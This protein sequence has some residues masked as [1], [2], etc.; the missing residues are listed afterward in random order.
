MNEDLGEDIKLYEKV[1]EYKE[2]QKD[3]TTNYVC[4]GC[5][6]QLH[7]VTRHAI[8]DCNVIVDDDENPVRKESLVGDQSPENGGGRF[9]KESEYAKLCNAAEDKRLAAKHPVT[10]PK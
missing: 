5:G 6:H 4:D 7:L 8:A 1:K 3:G 2:Q 9:L 10:Q